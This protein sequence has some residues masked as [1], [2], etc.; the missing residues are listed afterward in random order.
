VN[1]EAAAAYARRHGLEALRVERDGA[2]V[3]EE[4]A[5]GF[6]AHRAHALYSG[7][8]SFWG[9]AAVAAEED[10]LLHLDEPVGAT[11]PAWNTG[12]KASVTLRRLLQ[13]TSGIGFGG[14][15]NAVPPYAKA[16]A[17]DLRHE[18]DSTFTYGG[19]PL[20]VFGAVVAEKLAPR[21]MTPHA[22]LRARLLDPI[23]CSIA[24]WR[25]LEDGTNPLPT[26]ATMAAAEW[27][28]FGRLV[29]DQGARGK[30]RIVTAQALQTCF[31][32]S[33]ANPRYGLTWWLSPLPSD[34]DVVY[35]SGAGGQGLYVLPSQRH[36]VVK[37]GRS[38]SYAHDRF[39]RALLGPP[40]A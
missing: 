7:T 10:G 31:Q 30:R 22:Y 32:G 35:A 3:F 27:A 28:K 26:G 1:L 19:I 6:D 15:G 34:P 38:N 12:A 13:L 21:G 17:V 40:R 29:L 18:P 4:Y 9:V 25:A 33:A 20:Q 39:L 14:L 36:V 2:V 23:G 24:S 5:P 37:F 11:F 16:L 8:K